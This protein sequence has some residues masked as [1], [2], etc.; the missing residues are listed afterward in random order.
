LSLAV[1]AV[2]FDFD[3]TSSV[4]QPYE[5][6]AILAICVA[7]FIGS[8]A[9]NLLEHQLSKGERGT[10]AQQNLY[11]GAIGSCFS[12]FA[13]LIQSESLA[14]RPINFSH[15]TAAGIAAIVSRSLGGIIVSAVLRYAGS[16]AKGFATA[17]AIMLTLLHDSVILQNDLQA[18]QLT[19][20]IVIVA[21][22]LLYSID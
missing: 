4:S 21:S 9:G 10:L 2:R 8:L 20:C 5:G 13:L 22:T 1:V 7:S 14:P 3:K 6:Q 17:L 18:Y 19:A 11:L 15:L 12:G 16:I